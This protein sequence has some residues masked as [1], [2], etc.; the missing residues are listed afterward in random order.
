MTIKDNSGR[1]FQPGPELND[2]K[3]DLMMSLNARD[4]QRIHYADACDRVDR[5]IQR[6]RQFGIPNREIQEAIASF[7]ENSRF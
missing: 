3:V 7:R 5:A 6:A 4:K 1:E 2:W